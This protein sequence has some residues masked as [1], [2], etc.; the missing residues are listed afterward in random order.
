MQRETLSRYLASFLHVDE[1]TD[2]GP[3]GLQ[4]AGRTEINRVVTAVSASVE[5]FLRAAAEKAD[6]IIVHHGIIWKNRQPIYTGGYRER[7]RLLLENN[8][9]LFAYH[10]PLD[11]HPQVGNNAQLGLLLELRNTE[12][13]GIYEGRAIGIRGTLEEEPFEQFLARVETVVGRKP[14]VFPYGPPSIRSV[15]IISGGAPREVAQAVEQ[16]LDAY[17]TGEVTEATLHYAKEER[18]HFVA[19]GHYATEK[20]GV[21]ALGKH[22]AERFDLQVVFVDVPNPV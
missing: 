13:F 19:A 16:G 17:L 5:L 6:A 2:H 21:K 3:N 20:F 14:L 12:S 9:N 15:G 10:L 1:F 4:V 22:L 8:L 11:A 7:I 18:I